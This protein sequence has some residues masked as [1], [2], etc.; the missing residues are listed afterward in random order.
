MVGRLPFEGDDR[1]VLAQQIFAS[2]ESKEL[3]GR[4]LSPHV[5]Y[6]IEKM[7]AKDADDRYQS[8]GE[9]IDD[10]RAQVEGRASLDLTLPGRAARASRSTRLRRRRR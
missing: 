6:F 10:V 9:L 3:Q 2:L 5:Q 7:M 8:W 1:E 4:S